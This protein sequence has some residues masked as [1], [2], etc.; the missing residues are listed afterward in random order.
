MRMLKQRQF[1]AILTLLIACGLANAQSKLTPS[2]NELTQSSANLVE[3]TQEYHARSAE[4]VDIQEKE[5]NKATAKLDVL[6][7]LVAEG[8]VAKAELEES[9]STVIATRSLL[10]LPAWPRT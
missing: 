8:L 10:A 4:L 2:K 9:E 3:A 6:R 5:V 7:Q 1:A